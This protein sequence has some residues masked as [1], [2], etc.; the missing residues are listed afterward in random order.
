VRVRVP[1]PAYY[2]AAKVG[3]VCA[4]GPLVRSV[5]SVRWGRLSGRWSLCA[6][7]MTSVRVR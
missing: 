4:L 3:G 2:F 1:H 7:T 5:E 6:G